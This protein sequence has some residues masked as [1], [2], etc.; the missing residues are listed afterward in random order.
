[1][2]PTTTTMKLSKNQFRCF[3]CRRVFAQR[4]GDWINWDSM[5]VHLCNSCNKLT[6]K[7][8]ERPQTSAVNY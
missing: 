3:H 6:A 1:M 8:P 4:D 2:I 5:Q 7:R